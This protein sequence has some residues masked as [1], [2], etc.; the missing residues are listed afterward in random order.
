[1]SKRPA[2]SVHLHLSS[3]GDV[4]ALCKDKQP[5]A[6]SVMQYACKA[7]L[8]CTYLNPKP[9]KRELA[10]VLRGKPLPRSDAC[11]QNIEQLLGHTGAQLASRRLAVVLWTS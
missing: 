8:K 7:E 4:E 1:M 5:A 9:I 6:M 10:A 2:A 3:L 11:I